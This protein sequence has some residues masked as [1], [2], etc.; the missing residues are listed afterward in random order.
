L[1]SELLTRHR[2]IQLDLFRFTNVN[3]PDE[4]DLVQP[5]RANRWKADIVSM[6]CFPVTLVVISFE[7]LGLVLPG[8]KLLILA[9]ISPIII[10]SKSEEILFM[11]SFKSVPDDG[12]LYRKRMYMLLSPSVYFM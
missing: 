1:K 9:F 5:L 6:S 7:F 10:S 2:S 8:F 3:S 4:S 12:G 11:I